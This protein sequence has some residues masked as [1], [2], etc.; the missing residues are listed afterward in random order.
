MDLRVGMEDL[1]GT[2]WSVLSDLAIT[3]VLVLVVYMVLEFV[4]TFRERMINTE[5]SRRQEYVRNVLAD[6]VRGRWDFKVD[7][8]APD[9]QR[10]TFSSEVLF[11]TC[12]AVLRPAG[13][14]LL[15][16]VGQL[17][18]QEDSL[19]ESVEVEGHTDAR[20]IRAQ[21]VGLSLPV[22]L[23]VVFGTCHQGRQSPL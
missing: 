13:V 6:S 18:G 4:Q 23:G 1:E 5:L 21:G 19:F 7:S 9:R 8:I 22:Q 2:P 15:E 20:P 12:R 16:T 14:A 11:E 10:I 3:I 17:L